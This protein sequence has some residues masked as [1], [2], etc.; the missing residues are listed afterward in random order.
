MSRVKIVID[1]NIPTELLP[2]FREAEKD[3]F[4]GNGGGN[5]TDEEIL[6]ELKIFKSTYK[7]RMPRLGIM[8]IYFLG[9][10]VGFSIPRALVEREF[11]AHKITDG[12]WYRVGTV[13]I[14]EQRRG[15]GIMKEAL[16]LFITRYKNVMWSCDEK[17]IASEKTALSV[18]M[19]YSHTIYLGKDGKWET[20]P[21]RGS[22]H[23]IKIFKTS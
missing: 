18:G 3:E 10:L 15:L 5:M 13:F 21:F 16:R 23:A 6:D 19:I 4:V 7:G 22:L 1:D 9:N 17:N 8:K 2:L 11:P 14:T 12:K 20:E